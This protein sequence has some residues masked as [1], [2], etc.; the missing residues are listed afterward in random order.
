[1]GAETVVGYL[2][3]FIL[4]IKSNT[5]VI[6][7]VPKKQVNESKIK[8]VKAIVNLMRG[9]SFILGNYVAF[10]GYSPK[11]LFFY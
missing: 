4:G 10:V 9:I 3:S 7:C 8:D 6:R 1:M 2:M 5:D 11:V